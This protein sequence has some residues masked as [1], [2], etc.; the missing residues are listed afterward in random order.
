MVVNI[1]STIL[2][3]GLCYC[4]NKLHDALEIKRLIKEGKEMEK[5]TIIDVEYEI[6]IDQRLRV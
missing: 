5:E 4:V 3:I 6:I 1:I 2:L